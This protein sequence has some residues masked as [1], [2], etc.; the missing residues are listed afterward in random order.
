[1]DILENPST[2]SKKKTK[3]SALKKREARKLHGGDAPI[4]G[5]SIKVGQDNSCECLIL[6]NSYGA[7]YQPVKDLLISSIDCYNYDYTDRDYDLDAIEDL[8]YAK[9]AVSPRTSKEIAISLEKKSCRQQVKIKAVKT[10]RTQF[11]INRARLTLLLLDTGSEYICNHPGCEI[12]ED[13][14]IDHIYPLSRGGDDSVE[15]L[16]FLCRSHNSSKNDK[17]Q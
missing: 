3:P 16:Q 10:R 15:N 7:I 5:A 1:M 17:I 14:T 11:Q 6:E 13:L 4:S 2:K 8:H 12:D 9:W